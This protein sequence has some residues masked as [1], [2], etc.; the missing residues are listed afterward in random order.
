MPRRFVKS[1][2]KDVAAH[3]GV[4]VTT[5]SSFVNGREGS[6]SLETAER[7]RKSVAALHYVSGPTVRGARQIATRTIGVCVESAA[8]IDETSDPRNSYQERVWRAIIKESDAARYTLMHYPTYIRHGRSAD[9]FLNGR[10]DGLLIGARRG[11]DRPRTV[12]EAGLPTV[13]LARSSDLP[14]G[15]G[16]VFANETDTANL[17]LSHLWSL[18]HRR[19]A[20][21]AGPVE[22]PL[23]GYDGVLP[24]RLARLAGDPEAVPSDTAMRRCEAYIDWMRDH[25]V[26]DPA[27][28]AFGSSWFWADADGALA[29]W[30]TLPDPPTAV[31]CANDETALQLIRTAQH[32][33]SLRIPEDLSV[34]G[35]DNRSVGADHNPSL[36]SVDIPAERIGQES[37]RLLLSLMDDVAQMDSLQSKPVIVTLPI[38]HISV[39][40]SSAAPRPEKR[41]VFLQ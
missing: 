5:V 28:L 22:L 21:L 10:I 11:D 29:S 35:V 17:A 2:I 33:F 31:W 25:G 13:V 14:A 12:V 16:A 20:H 4:S 7:I 6:C 41:K 23:K 19:I 15:C 34:V 40:A 27:L 39:R 26:Y 8:D 24:V 18:G 9:A 38:T 3:A 30:M 36:T 1:T 32:H 37:T